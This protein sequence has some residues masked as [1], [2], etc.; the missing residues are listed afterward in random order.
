MKYWNWLVRCKNPRC[1]AQ[2][3]ILRPT[4]LGKGIHPT[5]YPSPDLQML[6]LCPGCE[7]V[8]IYKVE[9][10]HV[11]RVRNKDH[12][13]ASLRINLRQIRFLCAEENCGTPAKIY[14]HAELARPYSESIAKI[15]RSNIQIECVS[16]RAGAHRLCLPDISQLNPSSGTLYPRN[17]VP[18]TSRNLRNV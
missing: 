2:I 4:L 16:E 18:H 10:F 8:Y 12:R 13:L 7:F 1:N 6:F 3:Q 14:M 11:R 9:D 17:L 5:K 15:V